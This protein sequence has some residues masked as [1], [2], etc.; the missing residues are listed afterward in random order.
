MNSAVERLD[1]YKSLLRILDLYSDALNGKSEILAA[2]SNFAATTE[3][4]D[5]IIS[6]LVFP[7]AFIRR[8]QV[9]LRH[10]LR[11]EFQRMSRI[12]ILIAK[13]HNDNFMLSQ[14]KGYRNMVYTLN[15]FS[16]RESAFDLAD[17]LES[18]LDDAETIGFTA[19][20]ITAFRQFA[21]NF[22]NVMQATRDQLVDRRKKRQDVRNL[23]RV[24]NGILKESLDP[25]VQISTLAYPDLATAY[26]LIRYNSG[27][28]KT[29]GSA[30]AETAEISG[31]VS[32]AAT[33]LPIEGAT[34]FVTAYNLL[35]DTDADGCYV[36]EGLAPGE[37]RVGCTANGYITPAV[38]VVNI[39]A[40]D[41]AD[42][43]IFLSALQAT[44]S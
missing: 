8:T 25:F 3:Q 39:A 2:K 14:M 5:G 37:Y 31:T 33:N 20:D 38:V 21:G 4:L 40:G 24:C 42:A 27:K 36:F 16:L 35:A 10:Q 18:Y 19:G 22:A 28:S 26:K 11:S 1:R 17:V 6:D 23:F 9:D 29:A 15:S 43:D 41:S 30:G 13:K 7:L 12:G 32:D 34:V 44:S